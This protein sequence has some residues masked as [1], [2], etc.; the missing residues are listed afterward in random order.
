M[1]LPPARGL[2]FLG[3]LKRAALKLFYNIGKSK[4]FTLLRIYPLDSTKLLLIIVVSLAVCFFAQWRYCFV[5][6]S[7]TIGSNYN[8]LVHYMLKRLGLVRFLIEVLISFKK[9]TF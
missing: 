6:T 1:C 5:C 8:T 2:G 4:M 9:Q 3:N 7:S